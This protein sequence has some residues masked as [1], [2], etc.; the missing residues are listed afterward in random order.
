MF[1]RSPVDPVTA[2]ST[3][4]FLDTATASA[5]LSSAARHA[6]GYLESLQETQDVPSELIAELAQAVQ[7]FDHS[8][9]Y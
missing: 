5:R 7:V 6:L 9:L 8:L 2:D 4:R 3:E 1:I